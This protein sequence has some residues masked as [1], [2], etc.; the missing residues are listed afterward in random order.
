MK[1]IP[2][3]LQYSDEYASF[4][5]DNSDEFISDGDMLTKL[6]DQGHL[7]AEFVASITE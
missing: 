7:F 5:L 6:M 3:D 1:T 2:T 4:I